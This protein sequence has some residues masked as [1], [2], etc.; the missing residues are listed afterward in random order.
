MA[1]PRA[2]FPMT[3]FPLLDGPGAP[4]PGAGDATGAG[5][6]ERAGPALIHAGGELSWED[7]RRGLDRFAAE[8]GGLLCGRPLLLLEAENAPG[9][10]TAYLAALRAGWPV[11]LGAPGTGAPDHPVRRTFAPNAV[12]RG[13]GTGW[14][15]E[16]TGAPPAPMHPDLAVLLSTSGTTG[17]AKLVRLSRGALRSNAEA[18]ATY[19]GVSAADRAITALPFHY[20]YGMSV[21]HVQM[22]RGAP[23]ILTGHSVSELGFADLAR[24]AGATSLALVP[25]QIEM[26]EGGLW[27][28]VRP[29]ALRYVTQAGGRLEAA[30]AR[31]FADRAA[32]EGWE[33]F[34]MYGQ[35]EA[36][37]RIAYLP[38]GDARAHPDCI[39]RAIPGSRLVLR[40]AD[41]APVEG[42][43][44]PGE[45][46]VEGPGIMQGYATRRAHLND[47]E[48]PRELA[49]GDIAERTPEGHFRIIGRRSRFLKLHGLRI[50]LD[51][52]ET[53]LA[54]EGVPVLAAGSD[55]T[56]LV[57]FLRGGTEAEA[58][59]VARRCARR[60]GLPGDLVLGAPLGEVPLLSSGKTDYR[61]LAAR[62]AALAAE[63]DAKAP[64]GAAL[65]PLLA[66][67]LRTERPD[68]SR[69]FRDLG[70]D[71]LGYLSVQLH[72][73]ETGRTL[74]EDWD[75]RPLAELLA[76]EKQEAGEST[77]EGAEVAG[78]ARPARA[79]ATWMGADLVMRIAALLGVIALHS[80]TWPTGG[81]AYVLL[82]LTGFSLARFQ[83][84]PLC[85]GELGRLLR[86]M[87]LP[88]LIAYYGLLVA[89]H[90]LWKPVPAAMYLLVANLDPRWPAPE[91]FW[92]VSAYVQ[93][94]VIAAAFF[95][96]ARAR[97]AAAAAP[98]AAG[99]VV[100]GLAA[101]AI[102]A[103][104]QADTAFSLRHRHPAAALELAALGWCLWFADTRRARLAMTLVIALIWRLQWSDM[105]PG[106]A[107]F[108]FGG[109]TLVLW[110]LK[111]PAPPVLL[112]AL[113]WIGSLALY[114]YL[115]HVVIISFT[116]RVLPPLPELPRFVLIFCLTL[117]MARMARWAY[118]LARLAA[119][120]IAARI[121]A[122][123]DLIWPP[124]EAAAIR[125]GEV[126]A[127]ARAD[128]PQAEDW[129]AARG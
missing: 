85:R 108:C 123:G 111:L 87:L 69:S 79:A 23:L 64:D 11:I 71:S 34:L 29:P 8:A 97:A 63:R 26:L 20:S 33:L 9:A 95:A 91:P 22:L 128:E 112:R 38:P 76:S 90:L 122:L 100:L 1:F 15:I 75:N 70:G 118:D 104:A 77:G 58:G 35:T 61:A 84:R 50:G 106:V 113:T 105:P 99:L 83:F 24:T 74:A 115:C 51:E 65:L 114:A 110:R 13:D 52:V 109:L 78:G 73:A 18:I 31:R 4:V 124:A 103:L 67:T 40:G 102:D 107:A 66:R 56:G 68:P 121:P 86:V 30:L 57:L 7:L 80:T 89:T 27:E 116:T 125:A 43:G 49:T 12:V 42:A 55:E 126:R 117:V 94:I 129:A 81:G 32:R 59:A 88:M 54:A 2:R 98:L 3:L 46:V 101:L 10:V 48:G 47:P 127:K 72:F 120:Q 21:L 44:R 36:G 19:L 28:R 62:A 119:Q 37:P 16:P 6:A 60:F 17:A 14:R 45:L 41:G 93:V 82:G 96:S 92:F 25:S 53:R 39:G 5:G